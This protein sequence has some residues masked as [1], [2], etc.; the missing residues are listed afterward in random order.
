VGK[1]ALRLKPTFELFQPLFVVLCLFEFLSYPQRPEGRAIVAF[2]L[3]P[4]LELPELFF[5]LF[6]RLDKLCNPPQ[7][8]D[9]FRIIAFLAKPFFE[10][11]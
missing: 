5:V 6:G 4:I 10:L 8:Q 11:P 3:K 7:C 1:I 2:R 9:S